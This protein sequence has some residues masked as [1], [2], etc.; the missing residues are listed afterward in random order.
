MTNDENKSTGEENPSPEVKVDL[1]PTSQ[2]STPTDDSSTDET[3]EERKSVADLAKAFLSDDEDESSEVE[4]ENEVSE[5]NDLTQVV[6]PSE[7]VV[8][9]ESVEEKTEQVE[10]VQK[11]V[12]EEKVES[13]TTEEE[14][15]TE[16]AETEILESSVE[17]TPESASEEVEEQESSKKIDEETIEEEPTIESA[18][19]ANDIAV[20]RED[21]QEAVESTLEIKVD[22]VVD[23]KTSEAKEVIEEV[24]EE[25]KEVAKEENKDSKELEEIE[26]TKF[27]ELDKDGLLELIE[28]IANKF[29][30]QLHGKTLGAIKDAHDRIESSLRA[31][32]LTAFKETGGEEAD[33]E[34]K[35]DET[36]RKFSVYYNLIRNNRHKH[37]KELEKEKDKNLRLKNE[38]LEK[39]REVVDD[40]E[41]TGSLNALKEIQNEWKSIGPVLPQYNKTLWANYHALIDRFYDHRSIYFELKELDRKKN[42]EAKLDLCKKAE[43]LDELENFKDAIQK[44]NELHEEF[45]HLGP[46]PKESQNELWDRFKTASDQIYAK[47]KEFVSHLKDQQNENLEQKKKL[48]DSISEFTSFNSEKISDWNKKTKEVLA[49]QKQW[50]TIGA[51][52]REVAKGI[53]KQFWGGLKTFFNNKS[54]FFKNLESLKD[55]NLKL[56]QELVSQAEALK[57]N[58]DWIKT[59]EELKGLQQKW[60][61][62][63][64]V[65]EK[66]RNSIYKSFKEA[67]DSFFDNKRKHH[68]GQDAE[69]IDNLKLKEEICTELEK[70]AASKD[71]NMDEVYALQDKFNEIG[72][73]PRKNIKPIQKRYHTALDSLVSEAKNLDKESKAEFKSLINIHDIK[74]GPNADHK[75]NRKEYG[76][77]KK[78]S[79]LES[80]ISTWKNNIGFFASSKNA[81]VLLKDF[82]EKIASA[83]KELIALKDELRLIMT[84]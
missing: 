71:V 19:E 17:E 3:L 62:I 40:E 83:E 18:I 26:A 48:A 34:Y 13:K 42:L 51:M 60:R 72:F 64:P 27:S 2:N 61:D 78:I 41:S 68:Q 76:L 20:T 30:I 45:K 14:L 10:M 16:T 81:D 49:A 70:I 57:E 37:F 35:Y 36:G 54:A 22:E 66:Y 8:V 77:K 58:T 74:S 1:D 67:C 46:V 63:G 79:T 43:E 11:E 52:P 73:V 21:A 5:P 75:L 9:K 24:K 55:S 84:I 53:N 38:L 29:S 32:A 15:V 6:E 39:L 12:V 82:N 33:F 59:A 25:P 80:D 65:P 50:E 47:R 23:D 44:L 4:T 7:S 28:K 31:E 69:Y 56:K